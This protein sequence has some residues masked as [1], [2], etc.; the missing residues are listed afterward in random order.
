[1][2]AEDIF[3]NFVAFIKFLR[4]RH[5]GNY[6]ALFL[7]PKEPMLLEKMMISYLIIK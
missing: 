3:V 5:L 1:M 2:K 7:Q 4:L 6:S